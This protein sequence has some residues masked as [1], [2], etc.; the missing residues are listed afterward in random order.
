M[1]LAVRRTGK[2]LLLISLWWMLDLQWEGG[3]SGCDASP[4]NYSVTTRR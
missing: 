4:A 2:V 3:K 1:T